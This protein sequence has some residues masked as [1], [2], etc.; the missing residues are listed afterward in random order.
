MNADRDSV[1]ETPTGATGTVGLPQGTGPE[2]FNPFARK[3]LD[4]PITM[5]YRPSCDASHANAECGMR[6]EL[7]P[8]SPRPFPAGEGV[9]HAATGGGQEGRM[10]S[11]A[12]GAAR[13]HGGLQNARLVVQSK[14]R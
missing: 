11:E 12:A 9:L 1:G 14:S 6:R 8:P 2:D 5:W 13:G 7:R 4:S 10:Q 3:F